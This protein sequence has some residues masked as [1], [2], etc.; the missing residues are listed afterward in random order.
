MT[1]TNIE[2]LISLNWLCPKYTKILFPVQGMKVPCVLG[3]LIQCQL[4]ALFF[5]FINE[6]YWDLQHFL[7]KL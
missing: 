7:F 5:V 6:K 4:A 2:T 1:Y 3:S